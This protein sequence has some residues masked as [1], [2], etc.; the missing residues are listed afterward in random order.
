M[1]YRNEENVVVDIA[2]RYRFTLPL[3]VV[4]SPLS[5]RSV[6][7][8]IL[9]VCGISML[10]LLLVGA[11]VRMHRTCHWAIYTFTYRVVSCLV[12]SGIRLFVFSKT[13]SR[14]RDCRFFFSLH[15]IRFL[16]AFYRWHKCM[17]DPKWLAHTHMHA[18]TNP[19]PRQR[20]RTHHRHWLLC[21]HAFS[22]PAK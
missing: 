21:T 19:K 8:A 9:A 20:N 11:M 7:I 15:F 5:I 6:W 3:P 4:F 14:R 17:S 1:L 22:F 10:L 16:T 12:V 18:E 2:A 13:L